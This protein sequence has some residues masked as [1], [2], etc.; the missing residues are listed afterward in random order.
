MGFI[1]PAA[2]DD[3]KIALELAPDEPFVHYVEGEYS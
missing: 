3:L 2:A 1:P